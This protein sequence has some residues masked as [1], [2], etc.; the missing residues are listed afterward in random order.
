MLDI[1]C[2][3]KTLA[4]HLAE[5]ELRGSEEAIRPT[6]AVGGRAGHCVR[7]K[8]RMEASR[9]GFRYHRDRLSACLYLQQPKGYRYSLGR[10]QRL[11]L[12]SKRIKSTLYFRFVEG[13]LYDD[14]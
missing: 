13:E 12:L 6:P 11:G 3:S 7:S 2:L 14:F 8:P 4:L 9:P 5:S 1:T 10:E